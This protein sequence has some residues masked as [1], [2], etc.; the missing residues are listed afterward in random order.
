MK[1]VLN[2]NI[3][4]ILKFQI[5]REKRGDFLKDL[6]LPFSFF[7]TEEEIDNPDIILNIGEFTPSNNNCYIVDHKYYIKENYLYCKDS[8]G[9]ANWEVEIS[10]LDEDKTVVNYKGKVKGR[11]ILFPDRIPQFN[12]LKP[13]IE[14]RLYKRGYFLIHAAGI[15]NNDKGYVLAGRPGAFK[16]TITMDFVRKAGFKYLGDDNVII[17]GDKIFSFPINPISIQFKIEYLKTEEFQRIIDRIHLIRY[18][19]KNNNYK[20][21]S[22]LIVKSSQLEALF[23]AARTNNSIII[24]K[25]DVNL[26]NSIDKLI[27]NNK[28]EMMLEYFYKYML[29]YSFVFPESRIVR[30]WDSLKVN[31][32]ILLKGL[33]IYEIEIPRKYNLNIFDRVYKLL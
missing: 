29:A 21:C 17:D 24:E 5:V 33:P 31:L 8:G 27:E 18:L 19:Y 16:S 25:R 10:G 7:E 23:F 13:L 2:Y 28:A 4:D 22:E 11:E 32:G 30:Y 15:S 12:I 20:I 14:Y 26:G 1:E 6:N 9:T 3:H